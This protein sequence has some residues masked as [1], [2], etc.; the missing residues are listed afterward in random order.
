MRILYF[1]RADSVH[2]QRFLAALAESRHEGFVLRLHPGE[3]PTPSGIKTA[4]WSGTENLLTEND[5][6]RLTQELTDVLTSVQ[7]DLV[8][9]G[10]LQDLAF[11]VARTGFTRL[12]SMSWGFD[13]M[14]DVLVSPD[15][16]EKA[17]F[18]L[19]HSAG[20]ITDAQCSAA[21]AVRLGFDQEKICIFPWGVDLAH[22]TPASASVRGTVWRERHGWGDKSVLLCLRSWEPNYGVDV[23]LKAFVEAAQK[24]ENLRLILLGDGRQRELMVSILEEGKVTDKVFLGGRVPNQDLITY[25][26]AAD[27]YVTPS[28]V[29]GSSV[30][31]M[32]AMACGLPVIASDIPANAEWIAEGQSGWL[33]PDGDVPAL[34]DL[35]LQI[36]SFDL[37]AVGKRA[38]KVAE[39]RADWRQNK[40][41]LFRCW[42]QALTSSKGGSL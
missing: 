37:P 20:L 21:Q 35:I 18:A 13:L 2:D 3:Y 39:K 24:D 42:E 25:Y 5:I 4:E 28:H 9:A 30:S 10:P 32:E 36:P 38:R 1:T 31:L 33:F 11:L 29:D 26:G 16:A 12:L 6:P 7:P 34:A 41:L 15:A 19:G 14:H 22:F 40:Q 23:L 8:H 17:R 27:V